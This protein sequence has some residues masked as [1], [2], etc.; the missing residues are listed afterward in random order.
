MK[1]WTEVDPASSEKE[2]QRLLYALVRMLKPELVVETG[3]YTGLMTRALGRACQANGFGRVVACD[4]DERMVS[5][6]REIC[7]DLPV[8]V[9]NVSSLA[10]PELAVADLI[11]SDSDYGT[12]PHEIA[13]AK[14]GA[15][16][17][18]HDT[19]RDSHRYDPS[20]PFLGDVVKQYGGLLFDA[21]RG[22]GIIVKGIKEEER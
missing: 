1:H 20:A 2:L 22:F 14:T 21:G 10:L 8:S 6:A 5:A 4:R 15:V 7:A 3:C 17:V 11:F 13:A 19:S 9:R 18:V 16:I 12:R